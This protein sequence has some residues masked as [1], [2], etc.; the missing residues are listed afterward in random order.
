MNEEEKDSESLDSF[1]NSVDGVY[2]YA[3][4]ALSL[5]FSLISSLSLSL[6]FLLSPSLLALTW[7]SLKRKV[8][9]F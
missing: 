2:T 8:P 7:Y 9:L 6:L 5:S 3:Q 1:I 4:T